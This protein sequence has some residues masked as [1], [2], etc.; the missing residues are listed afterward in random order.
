MSTNNSSG[1]Q[2]KSKEEFQR[3]QETNRNL[4]Q[5]VQHLEKEIQQQKQSYNRYLVRRS[6]SGSWFICFDDYLEVMSRDAAW[7]LQRIINLGKKKPKKPR[8]R[9]LWEKGWV[10]CSLNFLETKVKLK[11]NSQAR[12]LK[13]LVDKKFIKVK[14]FGMPAR[15]FI[16]VR[17]LVIEQAIDEVKSQTTR[18]RVVLEYPESG[19]LIYPESGSKKETSTK[20]TK[21]GV[22]RADPHPSLN[23]HRLNG[24][25]IHVGQVEQCFVGDSKKLR[26]SLRSNGRQVLGSLVNW[27]EHLR[28]LKEHDHQEYA[29]KLAWFSQ[30]C[31]IQAEH[32]LKLPALANTKQFR[33]HYGWISRVMEKETSPKGRWTVEK[34]T[35]VFFDPIGKNQ[36]RSRVATRTFDNFE[37]G[38]WVKDDNDRLTFRRDESKS[39]KLVERNLE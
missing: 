27:P 28:L 36:T 37:P 24:K 9:E 12:V 14:R 11:R 25:S 16:K 7:T 38:E 31:S 34:K 33:T 29:E 32:R 35:E 23:R 17:L 13:E 10:F 30:H 5:L 2:E 39:V 21:K 22:R 8:Q 3:L 26:D 19:S 6:M 1:F 15:R 18:N 4:R 20:E